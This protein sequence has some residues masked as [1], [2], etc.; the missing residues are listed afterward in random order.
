MKRVTLVREREKRKDIRKRD[1]QRVRG[2]NTFKE[3]K[4][5]ARLLQ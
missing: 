2:R 3:S 4:R 5:K 1:M